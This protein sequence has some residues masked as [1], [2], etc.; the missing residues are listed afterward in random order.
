MIKCR[1][2]KVKLIGSIPDLAAEYSSLTK[3][4][5]ELF[6][7]NKVPMDEAVELIKFAHGL[8]I[9]SDKELAEAIK[10]MESIVNDLK[11][12]LAEEE[13]ADE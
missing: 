11:A 2:G 1:A 4:M 7:S 12:E 6:V 13:K 8:G 3:G 10:S 9:K 5:V